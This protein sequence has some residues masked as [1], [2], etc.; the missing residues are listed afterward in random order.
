MLLGINQC[1]LHTADAGDAGGIDLR[2][3]VVQAMAEFMEQGGHF[4]VGDERHLAVDRWCE[5]TRQLSHRSLQRFAV[6]A[7]A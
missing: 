1:T 4:I 6:Q 5:V 7:H 2:E 3:H